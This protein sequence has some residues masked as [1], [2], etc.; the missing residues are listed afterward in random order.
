[1]L[2]DASGCASE[3]KSQWPLPPYVSVAESLESQRCEKGVGEG[4]KVGDP[5]GTPGTVDQCCGMSA[6]KCG[7]DAVSGKD[8]QVGDVASSCVEL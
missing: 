1:M 7:P 8:V 6:P 5:A 3:R 4:G 2:D